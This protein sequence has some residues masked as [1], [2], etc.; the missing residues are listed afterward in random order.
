MSFARA[1]KHHAGVR[2]RVSCDARSC[3]RNGATRQE[4]IARVGR[5][6]FAVEQSGVQRCRAEGVKGKAFFKRG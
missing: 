6:E 1:G 3:S 2:F 4:S 5:P